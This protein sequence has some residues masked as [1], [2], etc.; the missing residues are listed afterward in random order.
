[1]PTKFY[2]V[3]VGRETGVFTSW[4]DAQKQVHEF[5]QARFKSFKTQEEAKDAFAAGVGGRTRTS[6]KGRANAPSKKAQSK[7]AAPI[8][9]LESGDARETTFDTQIYCDGSCD[10]NPGKAGSGVVVYRDGRLAELWYGLFHPEGTNNTAELNALYQALRIAKED[11]DG[12]KTVQ[13]RCDSKYSIN[14][15]TTWAFGWEKKGWKR[16]T[17]GDIKN[18]EIIQQAHALYKTVSAEVVVTHVKAH[19]GIEGNELADRMAAFATDQQ[20]SEFCRYA[21]ALDVETILKLRTG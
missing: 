2:V 9:R 3:W 18:L 8:K 19:I 16:K 12:G 20:A 17:E 13:I 5:P 15:V 11:I 14:C 21:G 7:R 1:M 6:T 10:P 4:A